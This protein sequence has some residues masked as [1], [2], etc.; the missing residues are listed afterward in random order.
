[1]KTVNILGV[2]GSIGI[3]TA[4]VIAHHPAR[5]RVNAVSAFQNAEA[6][7]A[8]ARRLKASVAVIGDS[9]CY[10][11]LKECL[12]GTGIK[13]VAGR[14]AFLD[15]VAAPV[16]FTMAA[17]SGMAGL[18]PLVESIKHSK[19]VAIANKE[20]LVSAGPLILELARKHETTLLPVDSEHNAV[21][22]VFEP[23]NRQAVDRVMLTASGGPFLDWTYEQKA[24]AAPAQAVAHPNWV[25]GAKI[26]VDSATMMNKALE[27]IE[28]KHLFSLS[29]EKIQV[30]VHPQSLIHSMV[31]YQDG[32]VLA[33]LGAPDM[34]TPVTYCL[35][36][37]ER[38]ETPGRKLSVQDLVTMSFAPCDLDVF[39]AVKW[40]Y[41]CLNSG[42]AACIAFNAANEIA[43]QA[44]LDKR[45]G[46]L[47]ITNTI[48][49]MLDKSE[50]AAINGIDDILEFD[51]TVRKET[52]S[53]INSINK[54]KVA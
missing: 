11:T 41:E 43:V 54:Q 46:F 17:I 23:E 13:A 16:D 29:P 2:T 21:F 45:I 33:Q 4:D 7:A 22:Q 40:A 37:P 32:S 8:Q 19:T 6:L 50:Y 26:S 47:D 3:S 18:A 24:V 48:E 52:E 49:V 28:A 51:N 5:F 31:S 27:V 20:P 34:R 9:A 25:M 15:T 36:W 35:G 44:F 14:E 10:R 1:M 38:I 30:V 53:Y 39:P 42:S 12:E